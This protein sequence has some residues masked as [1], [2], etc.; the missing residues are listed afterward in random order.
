MAYLQTFKFTRKV[1]TDQTRRFSV[2]SARS[3]KYLMV[4]YYHY[5]NAILAEPLT[6]CSERKLI[7]AT[8][9]LDSYLSNRIL[10]PQY[11]MLDNE[12][13]GSLKQFLHDSRV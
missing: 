7:R 3:S 8:C 10:T 2:T 9:F 11:Q 1:S 12:F 13:P 4:L 6:S 5:S